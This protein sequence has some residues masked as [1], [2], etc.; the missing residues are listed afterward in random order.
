MKDKIYK[1]GKEV[2][3]NNLDNDDAC[4]KNLPS[5]RLMLSE[6]KTIYSIEN[7]RRNNLD[8]KLSMNLVLLGVLLTVGINELQVVKFSNLKLSNSIHFILFLLL[9]IIII[10][11]LIVLYNVFHS[12][13]IREYSAFSTDGFSN[14]FIVKNAERVED[15]TNLI[16]ISLYKEIID[17]HRKINDKKAEHIK[18][19]IRYQ[20]LC[21]FIYIL[22]SALYNFFI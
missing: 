18:K 2:N 4:T 3:L 7:E 11:L 10:T 21:L 15:N 13:K 17:E 14:D 19:S 5:S 6:I 16:L 12:L 9:F 20:F 8:S 22:Y 1:N